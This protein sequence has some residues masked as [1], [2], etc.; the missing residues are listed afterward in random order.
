MDKLD[1]LGAEAPD[2]EVAPEAQ[3]T[4]PAEVVAEETAEQKESRARDEH[5]RFKAKEEAP[6]PTP[7]AKAPVATEPSPPAEQPANAAPE[8]YVPLAALLAERDKWKAL[9]AQIPKPQAAPP[10]VIGPAPDVFADPEG[11]QAWNDQRIVNATLNIS[12]VMAREKYGEELVDAAKSWATEQFQ[13]RPGFAQ[14]VLSK[15]HP[16]GFAVQ[17][18]QMN[19]SVSQLGGDPERIKAFLAWEQAQSAQQG[20]APAVP[21]PPQERP[22]KSIA[23]APSAGGT[24]HIAVGP[25]VAF[26]DTIK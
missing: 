23:N 8:G 1:F 24:Q 17:Q 14:E 10:P 11:F 22:P 25:G 26:D 18:Y 15:P 2:G 19:Q 13:T 5:G 21:P 9:E 20:A 4:A 6:A 12:E 3:A 16:Y 7:E